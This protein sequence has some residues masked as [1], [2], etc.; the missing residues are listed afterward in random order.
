VSF[1]LPLFHSH[2][3]GMLTCSLCESFGLVTM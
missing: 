1:D 3:T 2:T